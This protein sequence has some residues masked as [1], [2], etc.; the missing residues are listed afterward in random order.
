MVCGG[1]FCPLISGLGIL[2]RRCLPDVGFVG[3]SRFCFVAVGVDTFRARSLSGIEEKDV[4]TVRRKTVAG[5]IRR[6]LMFPDDQ[7]LMVVARGGIICRS[8]QAYSC[9]FYKGFFY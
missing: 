1:G 6:P 3:Q 5:R 2:V 9:L 7:R 4:V 8:S